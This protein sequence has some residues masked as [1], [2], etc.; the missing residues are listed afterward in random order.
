MAFSRRTERQSTIWDWTQA[1]GSDKVPGPPNRVVCAAGAPR[2]ALRPPPA[3]HVEQP[4]ERLR[5]LAAVAHDHV[6]A[7]GLGGRG[8]RGLR[9]G[10]SLVQRPRACGVEVGAQALRTRKQPSKRPKTLLAQ[11]K[12][13]KTL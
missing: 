9:T 3:A 7:R 11:P 4:A 6:R 13:L 8:E 1:C 2:A 12:F 5:V 10:D